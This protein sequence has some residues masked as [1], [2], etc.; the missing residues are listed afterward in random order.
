MGN[1]AIETVAI[2]TLL[3]GST[4]YTGF[5]SSFGATSRQTNHITNG[6]FPEDPSAFTF[7]V[8]F[9]PALFLYVDLQHLIQ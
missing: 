9:F 7:Q 5:S 8:L 3:G 4:A 2:T 6:T 1:I